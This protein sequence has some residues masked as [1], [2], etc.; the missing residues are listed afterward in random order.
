MKRGEFDDLVAFAMVARARSFTR[1]AAELSVS[2]SALSHTIR[3]LESRLGI[4]LLARTTRSVAP[5]RAGAKL[6]DSIEPALKEIETGLIALSDWRGEPAGTVKLTTPQYAAQTILAP[7]LPQFLLDHP[8]ISVELRVDVRF[9][10]LVKN[11]FDAG[12]RWGNLVEQDM[13]AV[14][15]GPDAR[16]IVVG[17][18]GYFKRCPP[19]ETPADL[20]HHN[21][22]N[23]RL[24]TGGGCAPWR[25]ARDGKEIRYRPNGQL[26]VDDAEIAANLIIA[27]A[28][29]GYMLEA[30]AAPYLANGRL[31][32]VLDEWCAPFTGHH[33]Y[34]PRRQVTPALRALINALRKNARMSPFN[35][36][37]EPDL[38]LH[39]AEIAISS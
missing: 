29:L 26:V 24:L 27:G 28:G 5:T 31:I 3:S 10:D 14:R 16:L 39:N 20:D 36:S 33:L 25:F 2:P 6:L 23:Y 21:C 15:I 8:K 17:T 1:A 13:V 18:P 38:A 11:G 35:D 12:I 32:Q 4:Q 9:I 7:M 22:V 37:D 19:P 34:Y 30:R